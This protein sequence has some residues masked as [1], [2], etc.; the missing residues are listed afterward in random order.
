[1]GIRLQRQLLL[2]KTIAAARIVAE[3]PQGRTARFAESSGDARSQLLHVA[4]RSCT[5]ADLQRKAGNAA[6]K[7][8]LKQK[9]R[10]K[11]ATS[12]M[13]F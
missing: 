9:S 1:M 3:N 8:S 13:I 7:I 2:L 4:K 6:Q 5:D 12:L 10:P 11:K